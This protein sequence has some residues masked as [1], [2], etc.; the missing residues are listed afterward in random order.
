MIEVAL[1]LPIPEISDMP[2]DTQKYFQI[3]QE[4]LGMIPNVLTA[5]K[6][7]LGMAIGVKRGDRVSI[8]PASPPW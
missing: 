6:P 5:N 7:L 1:D 2:E 8:W 3:C 4:K